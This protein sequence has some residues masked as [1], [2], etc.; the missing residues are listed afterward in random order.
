VL[1]HS[2]GPG[3]SRDAT[4]LPYGR[5]RERQGVKRR[6]RNR[7][8]PSSDAPGSIATAPTMAMRKSATAPFALIGATAMSPKQSVRSLPGSRLNAIV[9]AAAPILGSDER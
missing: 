1:V 2:I 4:S 3:S 9:H 8:C 6:G 7:R 5:K